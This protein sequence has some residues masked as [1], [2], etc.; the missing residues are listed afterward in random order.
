MTFSQDS[1]GLTVTPGGTVAALTGISD[2]Q[3]ASKMRVL[4]ITHSKSWFN[5]DD[6]GAIFTGWQRKVGS[7]GDYNN[8]LTTSS[9]PGDTWTATFTGIAVYAPEE[10]GNGKVEIQIDGEN[11]TTA[12]LSATGT[13]QAQQVVAELNDLPPGQHTIAIINRG[14][15]PVAI[16]AIAVK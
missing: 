14:P 5:D 4:R 7:T 3:L 15:G 2:S 12:D 9:N 8:D 1:K 10:S 16:D 6:P 13:R 11:K